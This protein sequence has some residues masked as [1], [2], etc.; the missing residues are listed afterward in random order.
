MAFRQLA[1]KELKSIFPLYGVFAVA[2]VVVHLF[3]WYKRAALEQDV[4]F[5][6]S[7]VLPAFLAAATTIGAAYYQ[8]HTEWRTN[9]VYV[10][11]S[12]PVRGWKVLAAK[13]AAVFSLLLLTLVWIA[14]SYTLILLPVNLAVLQE[15]IS[16]SEALPGLLSVMGHFLWMGSI[17]VLFLLS[18]V[19]FTFL[20]GQL[21]SRLS[22]LIRLCAFVGGL[23]LLL[24]VSPALSG[25]LQWM[26]DIAVGSEQTGIEYVHVGPFVVLAGLTAG[27][28]SLNGYVFEN[29]VEV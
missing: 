19:Q 26:P 24:L 12:L 21:A 2:V 9:S 15:N 27:L 17:G 29:E 10:L 3:I 18:L 22:W 13:Q 4:L 14:G 11:L 5:V 25:L 20:C 1:G 7:L 8:L 28:L 16:L 23:W 6:L